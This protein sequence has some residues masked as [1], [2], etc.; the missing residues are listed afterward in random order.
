MTDETLP[1][2]INRWAAEP[3]DTWSAR[4]ARLG[5]GAVR[6]IGD[7]SDILAQLIAASGQGGADVLQ[8]LGAISPEWA[9]AVRNWR[10]RINADIAANAQGFEQA[11]G[12]SDLASAGRVGGQFVGSAPFA[13]GA[14]KAGRML[15]SGASDL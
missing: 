10:A 6:G 5:A 7:V 2:A 15:A 12:D 1:Q 4:G 11:A 3:G 13:P 8:R 9:D 14:F